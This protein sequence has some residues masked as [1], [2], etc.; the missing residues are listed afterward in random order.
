[1]EMWS[2]RWLCDCPPGTPLA[3]PQFPAVWG[4]LLFSAQKATGIGMLS[5]YR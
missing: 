1:M 3:L 2:T 4:T 5:S